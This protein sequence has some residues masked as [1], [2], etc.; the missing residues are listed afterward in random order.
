VQVARDVARS[1]CLAMVAVASVAVTPNRPA[2]SLREV[3]AAH[4]YGS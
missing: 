2:V 3:S 4:V 1:I